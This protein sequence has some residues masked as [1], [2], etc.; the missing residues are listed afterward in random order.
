MNKEYVPYS[1]EWR[2]E[3]FKFSK[4]DLI[5]MYAKVCKDKV[6]ICEAAKALIE[7]IRN[8]PNDTRYNTHIKLLEEEIKKQ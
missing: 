3:M 7:D 8:K 1:G 5:G 2:K 6:A 4:G